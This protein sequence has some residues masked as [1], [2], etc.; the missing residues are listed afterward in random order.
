[1][2]EPRELSLY[3]L[4]DELAQMMSERINMVQENEDTTAI[5]AQLTAYLEQLPSKVDAVVAVLRTLETQAVLAK[6]E[7]DRLKDRRQR[8]EAARERLEDYVKSVIA[9]QPD[10]KKG[11]TKKLEGKTS[12][13]ALR[14]NGGSL[15]LEITQADLVPDELCTAV[16]KM[17]YRDWLRIVNNNSN[18]PIRKVERIPDNEAIRAEMDKPCWD[19]SGKGGDCKACGGTGRNSVAGA[20]LGDRGTQLRIE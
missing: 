3:S 9:K 10:P 17:P 7:C 14:V 1:M 12:T 16:I 19:C 13:L 18:L 8:F 11:K 20:R 5:D 2:S 6:L 15:P 4:T